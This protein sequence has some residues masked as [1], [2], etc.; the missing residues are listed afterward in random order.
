M[1]F[2][3][4]QEYYQWWINE[5]ETRGIGNPREF[6]QGMLFGLQRTCTNPKQENILQKMYKSYVERSKK[7]DRL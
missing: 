3:E 5:E 7:N 6:L 4:K 1:T 2:K